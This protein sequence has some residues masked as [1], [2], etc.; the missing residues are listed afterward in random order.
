MGS[1]NTVSDKVNLLAGRSWVFQGKLIRVEDVNLKTLQVTTDHNGGYRFE[2]ID[3]LE[4]FASQCQPVAENT[5]VVMIDSKGDI[6]SRML[7][8]LVNDFERLEK[9]PAYVQQAK[10][11]SNHVNTAINLAKLKL[12]M[13]GK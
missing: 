2:T 1:N 12:Q 5:A 3:D 4:Y 8:G 6:M 11:R 13:N 7:E 9:D 10:Q